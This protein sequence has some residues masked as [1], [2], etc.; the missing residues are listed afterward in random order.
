MLRSTVEYFKNKILKRKVAYSRVFDVDNVFT[1]EVLKDLA[2]FCR[3][4]DTT[5]SADPRLHAVLE[6]R[7]EVWLRIQEYLQLDL[8]D[9]YELHRILET[10]QEGPR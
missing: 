7:R 6:G 4:H 2:K 5:F 8:D 10:K 3:A 1:K 9:I